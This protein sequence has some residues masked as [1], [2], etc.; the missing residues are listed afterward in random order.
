MFQIIV[1]GNIVVPNGPKF[2]FNSTLQVPAYDQIE[3]TVL[4]A[5][6]ATTPT[7]TEVLLISGTA[8]GQLKFIS[9]VSDWF[10]DDLTFKINGNATNK[11][12]HKLDQP[13]LLT[14]E[15]AASL[16]DT[17]PTKLF[18]KNASANDAKIQ[19]LIGRNA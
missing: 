15:G 8:A 1:R 14:G 3:A 10:G 12:V 4:K 13:L 2:A 9:I 19:I 11:P 18:F 5:A 16:L 6:N 7:E 17:A